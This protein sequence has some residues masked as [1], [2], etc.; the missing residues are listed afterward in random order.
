MAAHVRDQVIASWRGRLVS[1]SSSSRVCS[2]GV[3]TTDATRWKV[4][5][6]PQFHTRTTQ[7]GIGTVSPP[8]V[9]CL[10]ESMPQWLSPSQPIAG[11]IRDGARCGA[12]ATSIFLLQILSQSR[13]QLHFFSVL[14]SR[15][16][17]KWSPAPPYRR[18]R[19]RRVSAAWRAAVAVAAPNHLPAATSPKWKEGNPSRAAR[20]RTVAARRRARVGGGR[21]S[22]QPASGR[23]GPTATWRKAQRTWRPPGRPLILAARPN[24][25][26][27]PEK[28]K[29]GTAAAQPFPPRAPRHI[30]TPG[31][32]TTT[33][34]PPSSL[35][36]LP[37]AFS[38]P[39]LHLLRSIPLLHHL[40]SPRLSPPSPP[41]RRVGKTSS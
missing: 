2:C 37:L 22:P 6:Y 13:A 17:D 41:A 39:P 3:G 11:R 16:L 14:E 32:P 26:P 23:E 19:R 12:S 31:G 25:G 24:D 28:R 35:P 1:S 20:A 18:G 38:T 8:T 5:C 10:P 9:Q 40:F 30:G 4:S 7:L 21:T 34:A 29:K 36:L 15:S 27:A 33:L